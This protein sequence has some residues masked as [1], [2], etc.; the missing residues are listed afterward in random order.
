MNWILSEKEREKEQ[1][2]KREREQV[3]EWEKKCRTSV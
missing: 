2:K 3:K 1:V